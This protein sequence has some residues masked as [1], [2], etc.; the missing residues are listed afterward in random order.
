[1]VTTLD[2]TTPIE[3]EPEDVGLSS[4]RLANL[5][6]LVQGY[7]DSGKIPGAIAVVARRGKVVHFQTVGQMD[8]EAAR[9]MTADTIFRIY[10]MTKP[11]ASVALMTLYEEGK[12]QL[13]DPASKFIPEFKGLKV[14]AGG[15]AD[16]YAV[17][18][19]ARE[20][21]VRDLLMHT[22][23]LVGAGIVA[24]P[25]MPVSTLY[26]RAELRGSASGGTLADMVQR[27][28]QLPL[29]VDPG[30]RWIY[31]ISTD[32][33]G[34]LCEVIGGMPFDRFLEER[35][36]R[37]LGMTDTAFTV[38]QEKL[39][40]FAANYRPG[41]AGEPSYVVIDRPDESSVYAR[42]R[43]YFSGAGGL[44]STAADY[45]RFSRMLAN[46]GEMDGA[47][48]L[49][50]RTLHYMATNHLPNGSDLAGMGGRLGEATLYGIGFGLGFA[51]LLDPATAQIIGTP[52]EFYWGG[53]ASTA[54][55]VS[56]QEDLIMLFLT[57]L[58]PSSTYPFRRELRS[59]IY[60]SIID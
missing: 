60:G 58:M 2:A 37:P 1:M 54:F 10:S 31:G 50:P 19:P 40:R 24:D 45:M 27:L 28:G 44:V 9:P 51:V 53:A 14:F 21:T 55:F 49:G 3:A 41:G 42:P 22:S 47:R 29:Q 6:R 59:T 56:P 18:D 39:H 15:T 52:G 48:I 11:I 7:V 8:A 35:I 36:F 26:G 16:Q 5:T 23:G 43:T 12:F 20:M 46:G 38:P 4:A 32:L 30:S 57:Q 33:V 34:Y 13:D 25:S 17:R